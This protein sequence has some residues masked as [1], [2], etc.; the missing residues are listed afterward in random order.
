MHFNLTKSAFKRVKKILVY[1]CHG[2]HGG[3]ISVD[4]KQEIFSY[5]YLEYNILYLETIL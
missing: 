1:K 4:V 5:Q 2:P 3:N